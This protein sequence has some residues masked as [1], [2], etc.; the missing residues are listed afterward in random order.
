M[1]I[2]YNEDVNSCYVYD[3]PLVTKHVKILLTYD[4]LYTI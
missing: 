3:D 1:N 2:D 4:D